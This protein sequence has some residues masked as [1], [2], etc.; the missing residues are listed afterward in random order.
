MEKALLPLAVKLTPSKKLRERELKVVIRISGGSCLGC[1][2]LLLLH[3]GTLQ[4]SAGSKALLSSQLIYC[5]M[6]G[7]VGKKEIQ[8][9]FQ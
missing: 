4:R 7:K 2:R 6:S 5:S 9:K 8:L 3:V 1:R